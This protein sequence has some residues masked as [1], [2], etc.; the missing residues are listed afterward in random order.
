V[1][2][3]GLKLSPG[4]KNIPGEKRES[5]RLPESEAHLLND[6]PKSLVIGTGVLPGNLRRQSF[7]DFPIAQFFIIEIE[8]LLPC[9]AEIAGGH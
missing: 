9:V 1:S 2:D 4:I 5:S 8:K 6:V 7:D 3:L